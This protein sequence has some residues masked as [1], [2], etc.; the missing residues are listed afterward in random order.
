MWSECEYKKVTHRQDKFMRFK[1]LLLYYE[2]KNTGSVVS[3][4]I[5]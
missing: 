1:I 2:H 5:K 3:M 4:I